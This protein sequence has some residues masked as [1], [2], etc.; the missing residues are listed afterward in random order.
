MKKLIIYLLLSIGFVVMIMPFAW[1]IITSFKMPSEVQQ[2]PPKWYT[3]NFF[4]KRDVKVETK[5]GA[6]RTLKGIS[7]SE[8]LSFT[9]SKEEDNVLNISVEDDP[10]YRG[11]LTIDIKGFDYIERLS[12]S[13]FQNWLKNVDIPIEIQYDT[14]ENFFEE[15]FLYF[16]S[17][18]KPY[19]NRLEYISN[20]TGKFDSAISGISL[21]SKFVNRR[22]KDKNEQEKFKVFLNSMKEQLF[23]T[24]EIIKKYKAGKYL[25]LENDEIKNIYDILSGL[26]LNYNGENVLNKVYNNKVVDVIKSE[27]KILEFY[28][29]VYDYFKNIQSK[30]VNS[31]IVAKV[32]SKDE[33]YELLK[34]E[35]SKINNPILEEI[36]SEKD[37]KDLPEKFSKKVDKYFMNEYAISISQLNSLKSLIVSYKNLLIEKN[38]D[39]TDILKSGNFNDLK[40]VS[41]ER[42][43]DSNTYKI[44]ISKLENISSK[45]SNLDKFLKELML[46][47]DYVDEV[48]RVYNNS[49]NAWKIIKAPEFVKNI[50]VK[51][52]E[53]IEIELSN[54]SPIY[55]SDDNLKMVSL[56]FSFGEVIKNVFQNYVDAWNSAPFG[57]YYLNTVFVAT[58][59]TVLEVILASMAAY[60]FSWM[61]FPGRN[62]I[63]GIFLAT[64]MVPG[65]V[66]LVP[67]FIT[68]SKF[69]WIDTYYALII[70]WIVSVF[71]IFL[72]R[73]HFLA[74]PRELFDASKIDGCS[75]WKFLW[76]I[77]V[78]LSKPVIITGALLKFVGSWNGFLWV[79]IV[80]NSDKY[81]T[82]PVGLQNFS[83]DVGTLYN[84]LMA[85]ATFSILPV[86]LLFLFT[87]QYF[88]RGIARTGL[89]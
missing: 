17:G 76:K 88:V 32:M 16:N 20:L 35:I 56:K 68:V 58:A 87:Q 70:P 28:L 84:Q 5:I 72:M 13:Q 8:A 3:K 10:F 27:M 89:K 64:M 82:L 45:I 38:I 36:L 49:M 34:N 4:S 6:V 62:L 46:Y 33:K 80:T 55:L 43:K 48:R 18:S 39:Y 14:P 2:W 37:L 15:V 54:V 22:I 85:A 41:D 47:T 57:R 51:N 11:V 67:N 69:G 24:K 12:N 53:V 40:C 61:N 9:S 50:R 75:H 59:T 65:E 52:G 78:P 30:V 21:I 31:L 71:A 81:R 74:I 23:S 86:I 60:A 19:F 73:Q 42:L 29:K 83:S 66:L 77:V 26:D 44:F 63:F 1:M 79:L 7:L 25:V